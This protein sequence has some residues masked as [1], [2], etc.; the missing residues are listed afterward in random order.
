MFRHMFSAQ[1]LCPLRLCGQLGLKTPQRRR[2]HRG[3]AERSI[4]L[5]GISENLEDLQFSAKGAEQRGRN[6]ISGLLSSSGPKT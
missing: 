6:G 5:F 3:Y 4:Q 2:G 1:P